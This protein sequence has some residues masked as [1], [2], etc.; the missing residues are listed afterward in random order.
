MTRVEDQVSQ[1]IQR[2][3]DLISTL[4]VEIVS[5]EKA[6]FS[7]RARMVVVTG[8]EGELGILPGHSQLLTTI[9]PGQVKIYTPQNTEEYYYISGGFL[10]VQ[11]DA[12]SIL[13]DT[14]VRAE[15][16]DEAMAEEAKTKAQELL[17]KKDKGAT[18]YAA[19][20]M[21]LA[22]A[23]AQLRV[24]RLTRNRGNPS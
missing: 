20:L 16:I 19:A 1:R 18:D 5:V 17:A 9:Q 11:P 8:S 2:A 21:E 10:E 4:G 23:I 24:A 22:K 15:E 12:V 3:T 14:V 6:I 7:G 13:A